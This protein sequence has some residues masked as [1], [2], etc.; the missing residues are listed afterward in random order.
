M[1]IRRFKATKDTTITNAFKSSLRTRGSGSNM[2]ASD[3]LE[4]FSIYGQ[5]STS[6][7]E[8]S[9]ILIDFD[10]D[11]L[12]ASRDDG[13]IPVSGSVNFYLRMFNAEHSS[14][15]PTDYVMQIA[16]ISQSWD[17][18]TGLDM[19]D[20][21]DPGIGNGGQGV[22]W[23]ARKSGSFSAGSLNLDSSATEYVSVSDAD[24]FSFTDNAA[25]DKPFS[26]SAW[27]YVDSLSAD[28]PIMTKYTTSGGDKR[29]WYFYIRS[30]G[31]YENLHLYL[32]DENNNALIEGIAPANT[33]EAGQWYHVAAIYDGQGGPNAGNGIKI[34]INGTS[35]TLTVVNNASYV[36]MRNTTAPVYI[37]YTTEG[38]AYFDGQIDEVSVWDKELDPG[39]VVEIYN[40]GV[41]NN[42]EQT[43]AYK[44]DATNKLVAW[45]RMEWAGVVPVDTTS[46]IYDRSGNGRNGT[47]QNL[48]AADL[49]TTNY[50][51]INKDNASNTALYWVNQG[52]SLV[53][54]SEY[55]PSLYSQDFVTGVEDLQV[56]VTHQVEEWLN[57][58]T[59]SYGFGV[60][61]SSSYESKERSYYTKKFFARDSQYV[62]K[63]PALEAR[64]DS[65]KGDD[66]SNFFLSSSRVPAAQNLNTIYMYN[67]V[68]G[69][70]RNI[71][72]VGTGSIFLSVY[73]GTTAPTGDKIQF[74]AGGDVAAT[75]DT[76]VTGGYAGS[77][78]VYSASFAFNNSSVTKIFP[79]WH[80][81][82]GGENDTEYLTSSAITV[83]VFDEQR[84][85]PISSY[86][87]N[88]TNLQS[89]YSTNDVAHF[90][91][92]M[93]SKD[94]NPNIYTVASTEVEPTII[95]NL[96]YKVIRAVDEQIVINYGTGSGNQA[97]T[98]LS[99]DASGSYF[100]MDMSVYE[101]DFSYQI[102]F[103]V[104]EG[105]DYIELKDKFNF[106]VVDE[107]DIPG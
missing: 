8:L 75:L 105:S 65:S 55:G 20:Y 30:G 33:V 74:P 103:L 79:V 96:Y 68:R 3:I 38:S 66:T 88:I 64:W 36:I 9:R 1:A 5:A 42:L 32:Y 44:V 60:F 84:S 92:F 16:P 102:S 61:L 83:N 27:I 39:N 81:G 28:R 86:V 2:G 15:T 52:G 106:R 37:G 23:L 67:F 76:N 80:S 78:G 72:N 51:G 22:T 14:T 100:D 6:S 89:Q 35:Q 31:S 21:R 70:L 71:P 82:S 93:R 11:T 57:N 19:E 10:I 45:W 4:T 99:Y 40:K 69:Q 63:R 97:Y 41:P 7:S 59:A 90:R 26:I 17:E 85:Y 95:E 91:V 34:Y 12:S 62:L 13:E 47:G 54:G 18:G 50:A 101:T 56:D 77:T 43:D 49:L 46:T 24:A 73:S 25:V 48:D 107:N 53:T 87:A 58:N 104:N 29:E 98:K 94:W